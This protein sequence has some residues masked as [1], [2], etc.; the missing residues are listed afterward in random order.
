[1]S[2]TFYRKNKNVNTIKLNNAKTTSKYLSKTI[3]NR[4]FQE[5]VLFFHINL[6]MKN[7]LYQLS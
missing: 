6:N 5:N 7:Y 3:N 1:M 2:K 4:N